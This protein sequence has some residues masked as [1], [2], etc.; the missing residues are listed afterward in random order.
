MDLTEEFKQVVTAIRHAR[1]EHALCGG[2]ALAAYGIVR[3]TEDIDLLVQEDEVPALSAV[4]TELGYQRE[5]APLLFQLGRLTM[6][7]FFNPDRQSEDFVIVDLLLVGELTRRAWES[8]RAVESDLGPLVV[9]SPA[10]L[11]E[12]KSLRGSGQDLDDIAKLRGIE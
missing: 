3:A 12:L 2:F 11:I 9:V 5:Q 4:L 7:R 1:I 6:E 10:G 8:R